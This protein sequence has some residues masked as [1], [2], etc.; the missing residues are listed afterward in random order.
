MNHP[1]GEWVLETA[2]QQ[3]TPSAHIT[4]DYTAHKAK[5]S[6]IE[7]LLGK[8]GILKLQRFSVE[9]LE[10]NEDHLLFAAVT[11]EGEELPAETAQKLMLLPASLCLPQGAE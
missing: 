5:I 2:K 10:Q 3:A 6:V 7:A 8:S 4:F 9:A 1:L 11:D